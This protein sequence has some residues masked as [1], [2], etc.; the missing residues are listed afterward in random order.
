MT[1]VSHVI[2][3]LYRADWTR[4]S[5]SAETGGGSRLLI[6][7]GRRYREE[8]RDFIRGYDGERPWV[9]FSH[10][11]GPWRLG[12]HFGGPPGG[13]GKGHLIGGPEPPLPVL[14]CPAWLL[15]SAQLEVRGHVSTCGR[16]GILV[17]ATRRQSNRYRSGPMLFR[18][19]RTEAIVDAELGIL[20]R[21]SR[22]THDEPPQ[23]SELVS[24]DLD[25][26]TDPARFR[27]PPGIVI[28]EGWGEALEGAGRP[29]WRAWKTAA[30]LAAGG[31]GALIRYSPA[32]RNRPGTGTE[33]PEAAMPD[34]GPAPELSPDGP[35]AGPAVGDEVLYLLYR[36]GGGA[37]A[38][39]LH[40]WY[41]LDGML[42]RVPQRARRIGFGGLGL[43][44]SALR[45]R[46]V[47]LHAVSALRVGGPGQYQINHGHESRH[48]PRAVACDGERR[49]QVYADKV[50]VGPARPLPVDIAD[51]ADSSWLLECQ[52]SGG[53]PV[54]V[55]DR[56]AYLI[57][58]A[59]GDAPWSFALMFRAAVAIVDA[60]LGIVVSLTSYAAGKPVQ[61]REL[62]EI[63]IQAGDFRVDIPPGLRIEEEHHR[64]GDA[65]LPGP[66]NIPLT[67]AR[68]VAQEV[69]KEV[70]D[71]ARKVLRRFGIG[72][73][74]G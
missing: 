24:L 59:R 2:G 21:V 56:P 35:P 4:L 9:R 61:Q 37:F 16:D 19:D 1:D 62:R 66:I 36:S 38:A 73:P 22:T 34:G 57:N 6:A 46:S 28:G 58:V 70:A 26:V 71:A 44:V 25:P 67:A 40:E 65:D 32:G 20:L 41:D 14:L 48:G 18:F 33:D 23:V 7:P 3:L 69:G 52:L 42:A 47:P 43:L 13:S 10:G 27:P 17:A 30:G 49:W 5:L 39:T 31:L 8:T 54:M 50:T 45:E 60:E 51:L 63:I 74:P 11:K 12:R 68:I 55:G 53:A 64:P 29:V 15:K 72:Q